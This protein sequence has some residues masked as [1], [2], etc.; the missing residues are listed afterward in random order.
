MNDV[1]FL[2]VQHHPV[3]CGRLWLVSCVICCSRLR[4]EVGI[5][6]GLPFAVLIFYH[7]IAHLCSWR[8]FRLISR[9]N[10]WR[11]RCLLHRSIQRP[12]T[13]RP[14]AIIFYRRRFREYDQIENRCRNGVC[15]FISPAGITMPPSV[16]WSM[17]YPAT[18]TSPAASRRIT[19]SACSIASS[20]SRSAAGRHDLIALPFYLDG[21]W[22]STA[23]LRGRGRQP[24]PMR[25]T[26]SRR[27]R[28]TAALVDVF[29]SRFGRLPAIWSSR[30]TL[31]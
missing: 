11:G 25:D 23:G 20:S 30:A 26:R 18:L 1:V 5:A 27:P 19:L 16:R 13:D 2:H 31:A 21:L 17:F 3:I 4:S 29:T 22:D 15:S 9:I 28:N 10:C 14:G 6:P 24:S 8:L 12:A 7:A